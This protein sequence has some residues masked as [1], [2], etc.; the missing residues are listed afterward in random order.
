MA[1]VLSS[2]NANDNPYAGGGLFRAAPPTSGPSGTI[3]GFTSSSPPPN[4]AAQAQRKARNDRGTNVTI[5]YARVVP[6]TGDSL[7]SLREPQ[8]DMALPSNDG[9][10]DDG[11]G[12][13]RP[14]LRSLGANTARGMAKVYERL[15]YEGLGAGD[16]AFIQRQRE[17]TE[18][19][20]ARYLRTSTIGGV[21]AG[22][23]RMQKLCS[24]AWLRYATLLRWTKSD[25]LVDVPVD[26]RNFPI[27]AGVVADGRFG[28]DFAFTISSY[29]GGDQRVSLQ[30]RLL[31][32]PY[33]TRPPG[34][35]DSRKQL[36]W[37]NWEGDGRYF[38]AH[39]ADYYD[40]TSALHQLYLTAAA[41]DAR[42]LAAAPSDSRDP[43]A[44]DVAAAAM[45]TALA[46]LRPGQQA[47]R[48]PNSGFTVAPTLPPCATLLVDPIAQISFSTGL[49]AGETPDCYGDAE[50]EVRLEQLGLFDW[51]PDGVVINKLTS[52]ESP[53]V[54]GYL[55]AEMGAMFNVAVQGPAVCKTFKVQGFGMMH[56]TQPRDE[57]FV[58]LTANVGV[59]KIVL[60][61]VSEARRLFVSE[62]LYS[63]YDDAFAGGLHVTKTPNSAGVSKSWRDVMADQ[64]PKIEDDETRTAALWGKDDGAGSNVDGVKV[65]MGKRAWAALKRGS[66]GAGLAFDAATF[67]KLC[68][69]EAADADASLWTRIVDLLELPA[70]LQKIETA[71]R[72]LQ[73]KDLGDAQQKALAL[74]SR[75]AE[76]VRRDLANGTTPFA[77]RWA[78]VKRQALHFLKLVSRATE[79]RVVWV[80]ERETPGAG[81]WQYSA[82]DVEPT[83]GAG[84]LAQAIKDVNGELVVERVSKKLMGALVRVGLTAGL[85]V[86]MGS[87]MDEFEWE[88]AGAQ[89]LYTNNVHRTAPSTAGMGAHERRPEAVERLGDNGYETNVGTT[90]RV[91]LGGWRVGSVLDAAASPLVETVT[92][93]HTAN[94]AL[95]PTNAF[96]DNVYVNVEWWS[97]SRLNARF[98]GDPVP[99]SANKA[100]KRM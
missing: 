54:E 45:D 19:A 6:V 17:G 47:A 51:T 97:A 28:D 84:E 29:Y 66:E 61:T 59:A 24:F 65:A 25:A 68:S 74:N 80:W 7:V 96:A 95:N 9:V 43:A 41:V 16:V 57:M 21:G 39:V 82:P 87:T 4:V 27:A 90:R 78:A 33:G 3:G 64:L 62:M 32:L 77:R 73:P 52:G 75:T 76:A 92:A 40:T 93:A 72:P 23:D 42:V 91:V 79:G 100:F 98:G 1:S 94:S 48:P 85:L 37:S 70:R 11:V 36:P 60:P 35:G 58:V 99:R 13:R 14:A 22:V 15:Q 2:V 31:V 5:P 18:L 67:T 55:N 53:F 38:R 30:D 63:M 49:Y 71:V 46:A 26:S 50:L 8:S 89:Q 56:R 12:G 81:K 69:T 44:Y 88:L 20:S 86:A 34:V 10:E 83:E